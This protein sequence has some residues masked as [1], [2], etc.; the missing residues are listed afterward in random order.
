MS[1]N[2][3][4]RDFLKLAGATSAGFALSAC[5]VKAAE[6][7]TATF[8][9][10]TITPTVILTS[11]ATSTSTP[12]PSPTS[13]PKILT[14]RDIT[15]RTGTYICAIVS[16]D[17]NWQSPEYVRAENEF[18]SGI[19]LQNSFMRD[20]VYKWTD[21]TGKEF[22]K[23]ARSAN[24]ITIIHP[25]FWSY[26][27]LLDD[28]NQWKVG[29]KYV[30]PIWYAPPEEVIKVMDQYAD[31]VMSF[32]EKV[33]DTN[34]PTVVHIANEIWS[35]DLDAGGSYSAWSESPYNT[36][37]LKLGR[38]PIVEAYLKHYDAAIK[39][40]LIVGKDVRLSVSDYNLINL[41]GKTQFIHDLY[42]ESKQEIAKQIGIS[43]DQVQFDV[44]L[45]CHEF[46][47]NR[48]YY[49]RPYPS[50]EE[51][52]EVIDFWNQD[53]TGVHLTEINAVGI[54]S[55]DLSNNTLAKYLSAGVKKRCLSASIWNSLRVTDPTGGNDPFYH[56]H[57]LFDDNY[58]RTENYHKIVES[59][60]NSI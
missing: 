26:N 19:F 56:D 10:P 50:Q 42:L 12:N 53:F 1:K 13:T 45:E 57:N 37:C 22:L 11:T 54:I 17:E 2:L 59:V 18:F 27:T 28:N 15:E 14:F 46:V 21:Y 51:L 9:P 29:G 40:G 47:T 20:V 23:R 4:R 49:H 16:G 36:A 3:S 24:Q 60:T 5:G 48:P 31:Y 25:G 35:Y 6:A 7:P 44:S 34:P 52:E 39:L 43:V 32:V 8:I 41:G 58:Q 38:N 55:Q 30:D 33:V